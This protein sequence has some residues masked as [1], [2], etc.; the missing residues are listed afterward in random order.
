MNVSNNSPATEPVNTEQRVQGS[1][2]GAL[3]LGSNSF[4]LLVAQESGDRVQFI[5]K[6][7]EMVRLAAGLDADNHLSPEVR[8][9]ALDC[10]RRFGERLRSLDPQNVRVVGTNTLRK[11]D[12]DDF[13]AA[14]EAELGH[15]IDI[16][17]GL[18]EA[19]LIFMGV[20]HDLGASEQ[21]RLVADIGGG[22]TELIV[23]RG[24]QA[25]HL[26]SLYMG[27]VS[28]TQSYFADGAITA[29]RFEQA[30]SHAM[31]ELEPVANQFINLGWDTAIGTSGTINAIH[32][33]LRRKYSHDAISLPGLKDLTTHLCTAGHVDQIDLPGLAEERKAVFPGGLAILTA[34]LETLNVQEM[35]T[36]QSALR[37]GLIVDLVG[38]Q[39]RED[40]R[41]RT[42]NRVMQRFAVD[43][44]QA[45]YV[46]ESAITLLS[47]VAT[48]WGLTAASHKQLIAWA[49]DLAEIG[50]D[51]SHSGY[52]KHSGYLLENLEMPGFSRLEQQQIA[53]MVRN[54][55]RKLSKEM[56]D[57]NQDPMFRLTVL[58][59]IA[60]VL[61]R[62]RSYD[63]MPHITAAAADQQ[64]SLQFDAQWLARH[65]LT[66][67]DLANEATYLGTMD[68]E[69]TVHSA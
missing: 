57:G 45:R 37:E 17:S 53:L 6:H 32:E 19:R 52:H 27:C 30:R 35:S 56:F 3:D 14:A 23:G 54:H 22:S 25:E 5:D 12:S 33:I 38:R 1:Q 63:S 39:H 46:H 40:A 69:L 41:D 55:R 47:Q 50:M 24:A 28:L 60:A 10:L 68:F 58:L 51:V 16:I 64:L 62:S 4:H 13:I 36:S 42:V 65:P 7:K 44:K 9:R 2:L 48:A 67:L 34:I 20:C 59:R 61:H 29:E 21:R 8:Q 31:V 43:A 66:A 49:A 18:E 11:A 15:K 26:E